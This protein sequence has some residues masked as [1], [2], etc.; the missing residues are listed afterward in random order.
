M[1]NQTPSFENNFCTAPYSC[2]RDYIERGLRK[3]EEEGCAMPISSIGGIG[4]ELEKARYFC[5]TFLVVPRPL[6]RMCDLSFSDF[7]M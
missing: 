1:S 6:L 7:F 4:G 2:G 3:I 5:E